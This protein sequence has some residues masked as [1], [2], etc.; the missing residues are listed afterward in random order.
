MCT[1]IERV[2]GFYGG[3]IFD[4]RQ[5]AFEPKRDG[6]IASTAI[7]SLFLYCFCSQSF[8]LSSCL[9]SSYLFIASL[10]SI[11]SLLR[12]CFVC[13]FHSLRLIYPTEAFSIHSYYSVYVELFLCLLTTPFFQSNRNSE[14]FYVIFN[15][16][17]QTKNFIWSCNHNITSS[18]FLFT[19]LNFMRPT[20]NNID[21]V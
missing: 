13:F 6:H 3:V 16:N 9:L 15:I 10:F 1:W 11:S 19:P 4:S 18:F 14:R 21:F 8:F 20:R 17:L 7:C 12:V 2:D 5:W